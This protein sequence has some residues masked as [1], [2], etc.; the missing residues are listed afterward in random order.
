SLP[1]TTFLDG[2]GLYYNSYHSL[3]GVYITPSNLP[4]H[5]R[6]KIQNIFVLILGPFGSNETDI[7]AALQLDCI[8]IDK[9]ITIRL[10]DGSGTKFVRM[11]CIAHHG[12]MPQQNKLAGIKSHKADHSCRGYLISK[13][14]FSNLGIDTQA[15]EYY[16]FPMYQLRKDVTQIKTKVG[17]DQFLQKVGLNSDGPFIDL[18]HPCLDP[19]RL[20]PYDSLHVE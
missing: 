7:S 15:Q 10:L 5:L 16:L 14:E 13:D 12:D 18:C 3:A 6:E 1:Y 17:R 20:T 2:F 19:L 9:G 8:R 4:L 11:F